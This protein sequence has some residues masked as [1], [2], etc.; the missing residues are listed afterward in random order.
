MTFFLYSFMLAVARVFKIMI[1]IVIKVMPQ[2]LSNIVAFVIEYLLEC[3]SSSHIDGYLEADAVAAV[4]AA[5]LHGCCCRY[6]RQ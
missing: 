3:F 5:N 2:E 1:T 6:F 4:I